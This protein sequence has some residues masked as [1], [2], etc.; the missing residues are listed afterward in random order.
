MIVSVRVRRLKEGRTYDDF[1]AEWEADEGFG[2]PTRV[3]AAQSLEDPRDVI[4]I[5]FVAASPDELA[6]WS[7]ATSAP[8]AARHARIDTVIESTKLRAFYELGGEFDFTASP[9]RIAAGSPES[10]LGALAA[11]GR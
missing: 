5:G 1:V 6:E 8:E 4:T 7:A 9:R 3:F 11:P 10:L 2:M